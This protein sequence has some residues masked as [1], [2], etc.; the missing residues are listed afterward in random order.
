LLFPGIRANGSQQII[1]RTQ[2]AEKIPAILVITF[3]FCFYLGDNFFSF[4]WPWK[5]AGGEDFVGKGSR[6]RS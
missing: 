3:S 6:G 4:F 1:S 2:K 5:T